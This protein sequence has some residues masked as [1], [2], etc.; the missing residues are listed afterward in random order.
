MWRVWFFISF[1]IFFGLGV[2]DRGY[3]FI[4]NVIVNERFLGF[5][6]DRVGFWSKDELFGIWEC[7]VYM[8]IVDLG[9]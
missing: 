8:E 4:E 9:F 3:R 5:N 6:Y 7:F 2:W 1:R